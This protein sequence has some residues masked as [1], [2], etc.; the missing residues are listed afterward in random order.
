MFFNNNLFAWIIMAIAFLLL[1]IAYYFIVKT[2]TRP[3][4]IS[5]SQTSNISTRIL[6]S[7][8]VNLGYNENQNKLSPQYDAVSNIVGQ[9]NGVSNDTEYYGGL[10]RKIKK[11]KKKRS[12]NKNK[13]KK[14]RK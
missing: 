7:S 4:P 3:K 8:Y 5:T 1:Y 9:E 12:V 10:Y 11:N 13:Y 14:Y 2:R 6:P